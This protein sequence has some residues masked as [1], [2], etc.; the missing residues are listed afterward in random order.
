LSARSRFFILTVIM[1]GAC[2]VVMAV[3]LAMLF[4]HEVT[5]QRE[6][7]QVTAQSQARL[8][9]SIARHD[10]DIAG[11]IV[12]EIPDHDAAKSTLDQIIDA[13]ERYRGFGETGEFTLA[14]CVGDSIHFV[15]R[16]RHGATDLPKPFP[17]HSTLAEPMR[18][19]LQG[20]SGTVVGLDYR[21]ETVL[22]A[23][24][25]VA[26]LNLGIVAKID[27]T[28]IRAPFVRS[29]LSAAAVALIVILIGTA[30]FFRV[31]NPIIERLA[32]YSRDMEQEVESRRRLTHAIEQVNDSVVITDVAGRIEYVNPAFEQVTGYSAAEAIG[33]KSDILKSGQH[34]DE[35][36][37]ELWSVISS[38]KTWNGRFINKSKDDTLYVEDAAISPMRDDTGGLVGYVGV[39]RDV[40][41][42][43]RR[44][45]QHHQGQKVESIGRLAG[46]VAHDL[47]NLL[48]P[49]LGYGELLKEDLDPESENGE[50]VDQ[51]LRAGIRARDLVGQLLAFSRKQTLEYS[52]VNLSQ[53]VTGFEELLRRT[54][55]EDITIEISLSPDVEQVMADIGQIG[56]VILNLAVNAADAMPDGGHLIIETAPV[57]LDEEY[58]ARHEGVTPGPYS[59][60]AISD[61]GYGMDADTIEHMFE[62]FFTTK[63]AEGTGLGLATVYGIVKQH[64]GNLWAYS[65]MGK[66]STFKIYLP[67]SLGVRAEEEKVEAPVTTLLG[68]ETILLVEDNDQ[69]RSMARAMLTRQGYRVL[70]AE[71]GHRA[72]AILEE[73]DEK[74]DLLFT[75]VIMPE[76][77]GR[78]LF[79]QAVALRP[80]LKVLYMSGYTD[81]VIAHHGVLDEGIELIAKPFTVKDLATR[82]RVLLKV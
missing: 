6:M 67:V 72:L 55:R 70:E 16:H 14:R 27:M 62:P 41:E 1:I 71:S 18:R 51:I 29:G 30:L 7:L 61:T 21:G 56:Q 5:Q 37:L 50:S 78:D 47:N 74:V 80:D 48:T 25:P 68:S 45:E 34:D 57:E 28:E 49:I 9:E 77:N 76:M 39:M 53:A 43:L 65:E 42:S 11:M 60:L 19:A 17:L 46:G 12:D 81:N 32:K 75:D 44:E 63:G 2:A 54:I 79:K 35:F 66:G 33:Q 20:L 82:L 24:E 31:G 58:A 4:R 26:G 40:T 10:A 64:G 13:H 15:L 73:N 38:G 69:V 23:H 8:M 59:M 3:V 52:P 22:A 36:Y